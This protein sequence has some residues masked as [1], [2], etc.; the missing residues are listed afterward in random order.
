MYKWESSEFCDL[1]SYT[2]STYISH[3]AGGAAIHATLEAG[4]SYC[5]IHSVRVMA[6]ALGNANLGSFALHEVVGPG[7]GIAS[8]PGLSDLHSEIPGS[9]R[10]EARVRR[11]N[12]TDNGT[13][14]A[15]TGTVGDVRGASA[16]GGTGSTAVGMSNA[17]E[18]EL[19]SP[20]SA[21]ILA[22]NRTLGVYGG[23]T[24]IFI[25]SSFAWFEIPP[26]VFPKLTN[27]EW[28]RWLRGVSR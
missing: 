19:V 8:Y 10:S 25:T 3:V 20:S 16:H 21:Y 18:F 26:S 2:G 22:P 17:T 24:G 6:A 14:T 7:G 13:V 27:V 28:L 12:T 5:L 9:R 4:R 11:S 1:Q 15:I 23:Q